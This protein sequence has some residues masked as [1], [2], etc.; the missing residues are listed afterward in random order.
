[1][2]WTKRIRPNVLLLMIVLGGLGALALVKGETAV[3]TGCVTAIAAL[4][5]KLLEKNGA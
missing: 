5:P 4:G 3:T 1:M 2:S